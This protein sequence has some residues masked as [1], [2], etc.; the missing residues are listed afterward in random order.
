[1]PRGAGSAPRF[2]AD[3]MLGRLARYLRFLGFDTAY[4]RDIHDARLIT[5]AGSEDRI[6]LSRDTGI[7]ETRTV[8]TGAISAILLRSSDTGEQLQQLWDELEL[9]RYSGSLP[10]R[11]IDCNG[12]LEELSPEEARQLVPAFTAATQI[13]I[14]WCPCCHH[15]VWRGSHWDRL[16]ADL[17]GL[18]QATPESRL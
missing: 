6:L 9:E 14:A 16:T 15:A 1:M 3:S 5:R 10:E 12:L 8:S 17:A 7:F 18:V 2:L 13:D 4:E 11:C